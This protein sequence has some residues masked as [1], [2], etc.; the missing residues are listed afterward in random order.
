MAG[1][2]LHQ[3]GGELGGRGVTQQSE[4]QLVGVRALCGDSH[5]VVPLAGSVFTDTWEAVVVTLQT[6]V[7]PDCRVRRIITMSCIILWVFLRG[8][9]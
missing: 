2:S 5:F 3:R 6:T 1:M 8:Q 7:I 4:S 9:I